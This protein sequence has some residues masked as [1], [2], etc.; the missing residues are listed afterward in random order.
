M[1]GRGRFNRFDRSGQ[2]SIL[3]GSTL[4]EEVSRHF[5]FLREDYRNLEAK[6]N[7]LAESNLVLLDQL[8]IISDFD[9]SQMNSFMGGAKSPMYSPMAKRVRYKTASP[10][11]NVALSR[12]LL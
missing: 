3:G 7:I 11:K 2:A 9:D 5:V 8:G 12:P 6:L 4:H 1:G 10:Q